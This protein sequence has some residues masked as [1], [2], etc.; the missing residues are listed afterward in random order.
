MAVG[1]LGRARVARSRLGGPVTRAPAI[2]MR[3]EP[4]VR[5]FEVDLPN[6]APQSVDVTT[7][8]SVLT[9]TGP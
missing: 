8:R 7:E 5:I 2:K 3:E 6:V 1:Q 4:A 9:V